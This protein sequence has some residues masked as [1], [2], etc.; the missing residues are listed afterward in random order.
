MQR[1][2][3]EINEAIREE[4]ERKTT[5]SSK[6]NGRENASTTIEHFYLANAC[7]EHS[8]INRVTC[9]LRIYLVIKQL[10]VTCTSHVVF[11]DL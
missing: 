1:E 9:K 7:I 10:M 2:D 8:C 11:I 5:T 3:A 4:K 6:E